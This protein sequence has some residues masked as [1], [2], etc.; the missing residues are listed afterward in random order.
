M[1]LGRYSQALRLYYE[2]LQEADPD[3]GLEQL[4]LLLKNLAFTEQKLG[5]YDA[6]LRHYSDALAVSARTHTINSEPALHGL[7]SV[8]HAIGNFP[9]ALSY[10]ERALELRPAERTPRERGTTLRSLASLLTD[11]AGA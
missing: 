5:K 11:S 1:D 3:D 10:L 8:Y 6:A 4:L 2:A 9:E 7:G